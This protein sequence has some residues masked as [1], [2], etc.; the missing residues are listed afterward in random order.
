MALHPGRRGGTRKANADDFPNEDQALPGRGV[1]VF[2]DERAAAR[3]H[4]QGAYRQH[5][6]IRR[7]QVHVTP[8]RQLARGPVADI[9]SAAAKRLDA[10]LQAAQERVEERDVV[11]RSAGRRF[12]AA[13][14]MSATGRRAN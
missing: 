7:R 4:T 13:D 9:E 10:H 12:V 2:D 3:V 6:P 11:D 5:H 8:A 1:G 14:S